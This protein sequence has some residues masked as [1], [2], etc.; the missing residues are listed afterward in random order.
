MGNFKKQTETHQDETGILMETETDNQHLEPNRDDSRGN[1]RW[2]Q[3]SSRFITGV[4]NRG[5]LIK[6]FC[7]C[8]TVCVGVD[9]PDGTAVLGYRL[10]RFRYAGKRWEL[11]T[12]YV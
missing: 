6:S 4:M 2:H 3:R 1:D 5:A 9:W 8:M 11:A 12:I 7:V 10:F